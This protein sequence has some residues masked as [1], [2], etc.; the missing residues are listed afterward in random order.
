[1]LPLSTIEPF[2]GT[3]RLTDVTERV[4][5]STSKLLASNVASLMTIEPSSNIVPR[6]T[7]P[8]V[9]AILPEVTVAVAD[10]VTSSPVP[11]PSM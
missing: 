2:A 9:G 5:P 8:T 4:S 11:S 3:A 7:E 6:S 1:M 10:D